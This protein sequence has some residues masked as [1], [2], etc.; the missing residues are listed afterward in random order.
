MHGLLTYL[1]VWVYVCVCNL[2]LPKRATTRKDGWVGGAPSHGFTRR[3]ESI[4]DDF[5][6]F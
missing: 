4:R 5:P 3:G 1:L 6:F 2:Y